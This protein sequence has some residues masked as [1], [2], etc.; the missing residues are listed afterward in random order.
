M[1][2]P[3]AKTDF[4]NKILGTANNYNTDKMYINIQLWFKL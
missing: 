4:Q 1:A 3:T 2:G